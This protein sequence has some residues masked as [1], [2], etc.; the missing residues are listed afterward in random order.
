MQTVLLV[1]TTTKKK[2]KKKKKKKNNPTAQSS[3]SAGPLPIAF[4][5]HQEKQLDE[6]LPSEWEFFSNV[7]FLVP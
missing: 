7:S 4:C 1:I 6:S 3:H 5:V 2:K